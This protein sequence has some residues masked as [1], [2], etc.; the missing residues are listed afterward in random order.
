MIGKC[1]FHEDK[2]ASLTVTEAK[3]IFKC[4]G[5]GAAGD[6]VDFVK[7][8]EG[9]GYKAALEKVRGEPAEF[10]QIVTKQPA[11][12][13]P[14]WRQ[15]PPECNPSFVHPDFGKPSKRWAFRDPDGFVLGYDCRF[16]LP[17]GSK[18]V[19]P[20]A[21]FTNGRLKSWR[22]QGFD[23]PRPVF[24]LNELSHGR[25]VLMVEGCKTAR[26]GADLLSPDFTVTTWQ[27]GANGVEKTNFKT[28]SNLVVYLW[29]D[30]DKFATYGSKYDPKYG[31]IKPYK[32]QPGNA[33]MITIGR[34]LVNCAKAVY[35]VPNRKDWPNK[36]DLADWEGATKEE[37]LN[38]I[39][40]E[41]KIFKP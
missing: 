37:V 36:W 27:G 10:R 6:C 21:Y 29:P 12:V 25:P 17:D 2:T 1:P 38:Y 41:A 24:N 4:F 13:R 8:I 40:A 14:V 16:D 39:H 18:M 23:T 9:I 20:Y 30:N 22:W 15:I 11:P 19:I 35:W 7:K 28:L 32:E 3:D 34:M 5:C 31:Q 26:F 33:A